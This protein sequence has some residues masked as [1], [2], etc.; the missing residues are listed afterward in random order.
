VAKG[1]GIIVNLSSFIP[2]VFSFNPEEITTER[3]INYFEVPNIGGSHHELIF[4]GFSNEKVSFTLEM[5][6]MEDPAGVMKEIAYFKQLREPDA[7]LL[8]IAGSFFGNEHYP[9]PQIL[10]NFGTGYL[11]PQIWNVL[12]VSIRTTHHHAGYV[13]GVIGVPKRAIIE[14]ELSLDEDSV[15]YKS[16]QIFKKV[17]SVNASAMSIIKDVYNRTENVRVEKPGIYNP[18]IGD[19]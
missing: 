2:F 19:Y 10:F 12:N 11:V 9:P 6:D 3:E 13:R 17:M 16:E 4:V 7:G 15:L 8:G 5:I 1:H 18:Q 14:I